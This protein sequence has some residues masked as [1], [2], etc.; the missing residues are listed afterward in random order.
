VIVPDA[1]VVVAALAD[2]AGSGALAREALTGVD[3]HAPHLL[4]VEVTAALRGRVRGGHLPAD[5]AGSV[6]R[7]LAE[8]RVIRYPHAALLGRMWQLRENLT[9]Y[10]ACYLA[11]AELLG[12]TV[13]TG[14]QRM[15]A[16]PGLRCEVRV[17]T[18]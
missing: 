2:N 8:L 9:P 1:S 14:D 17:L 3:L 18:P 13:V 6:L 7:D 5:V 10:D 15:A 4:D 12:A 16:A 11:L